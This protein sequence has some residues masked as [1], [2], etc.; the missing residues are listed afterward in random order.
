MAEEFEPTAEE[1]SYAAAFP[2][3]PQPS[4][5]SGPE[6]HQPRRALIAAAEVVAAVALVLVAVWAWNRGI[7][8]L[9][10][11][12]DGHEPLISTRYQGNWLGTAVAAVTVA[13][14]LLLDAVRQGLLAA[15]TRPGKAA[16]ADV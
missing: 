15:R 9:A 1:R 16:D 7:S 8:K 4:P 13:A 3:D 14:I 10:Y 2:P 12:I 11:P 6:L 5:Q